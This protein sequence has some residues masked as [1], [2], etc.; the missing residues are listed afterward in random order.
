[1]PFDSNLDLMGSV[2]C[3]IRFKLRVRRSNICVVRFNICVDQVRTNQTKELSIEPSFE[4]EKHRTYHYSLKTN[5]I[6][7]L[8]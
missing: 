8:L 4:F 6:K 1:M 7:K 5:H 2:F 3:V